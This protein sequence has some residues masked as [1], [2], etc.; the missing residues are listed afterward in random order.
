[1]PNQALLVVECVGRCRK[2][3]L[4]TGEKKILQSLDL[5]KLKISAENYPKEKYPAQKKNLIPLRVFLLVRPL[6]DPPK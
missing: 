5:R 2:Q 1:M 3:N 6:V 4:K